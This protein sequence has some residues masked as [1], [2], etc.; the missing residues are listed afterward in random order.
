M[1]L[2]TFL[3]RPEVKAKFKEEFIKP[4]FKGSVAKK[5]R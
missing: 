1:S 3:Q 5:I 4:R 2:T